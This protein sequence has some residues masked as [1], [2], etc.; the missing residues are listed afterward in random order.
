MAA[1][2]LIRPSLSAREFLVQDRAQLKIALQSVKAGDAVVLKNGDWTDTQI[3]VSAGGETGKPVEVRAETPGGVVLRGSSSLAINAPYVTVDGLLFLGGAIASDAVIQFNS[4]HGIVRATAV[5]DYNPADFATKYYWVFFRGDDNVL[6]RCYFKG[7]NHLEPVVGNELDDSRRNRVTGCYFKDIPFAQQNGR[8]IIR[9]WG[10]GKYEGR[11]DDGAFF[12]I[13]GNLFDHADGEGAEIIS[14]KSNHNQVLRNTVVAT[15]GCINI[16][17]GNFNTVQG[18][19]LLGQGRAGAMGFRMSGEH[20]LV[21]GNLAWGCAYGITVS[22]GEYIADA[23][24]SGYQPNLK[25]RGTA[26]QNSRVPTY[27]QNRDVTIA[28][29]LMIGN[30]GP[31]LEIGS[32]Y[33]NHWPESQQVLLPEAC[34]IRNNRFVRPAGGVSVAGTVPETAPPFERFKFQPNRFDGNLLVGGQNS[35]A[36]A[37]AGCVPLK[38]PLDWSAVLETAKFKPLTPDEVGPSWVI[39]RRKAGDT[40]LEK[41]SV[42]SAPTTISPKKKAKAGN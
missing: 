32:S 28:D 17:R 8:E 1:A 29:N 13:E 42:I 26:K 27:P 15:L 19:I 30:A 10:S 41:P 5:V 25:S 31:D 12:T 20:N 3:L 22:C 2:G 23:L 7:K 33:K 36:P 24:T 38:L 4:H 14:L 35:Y 40:S 9:V 39:A 11:D 6:E 37:A 34:V 16:R 18:N 21:Q